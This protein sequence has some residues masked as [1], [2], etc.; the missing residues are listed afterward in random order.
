MMNSWLVSTGR[1]VFESSFTLFATLVEECGGYG[2]W[3]ICLWVS[4]AIRLLLLALCL[5]LFSSLY[6]ESIYVQR[7]SFLVLPIMA[8]TCWELM[9]TNLD[10]SVICVRVGPFILVAYDLA[11]AIALVLTQPNV[12]TFWCFFGLVLVPQLLDSLLCVFGMLVFGNHD[13]TSTPRAL[14]SLATDTRSYGTIPTANQ[15]EE[16]SQ[17]DV[18]DGHLH[19]L[20]QRQTTESERDMAASAARLGLV[21]QPSL[22][23]HMSLLRLGVL[24]DNSSSADSHLLHRKASARQRATLPAPPLRFPHNLLQ[25]LRRRR[26][27]LVSQI[28]RRHAKTYMIVQVQV[29]TYLF[30]SLVH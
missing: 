29:R 25:A 15:L 13:V 6:S 22:S 8:F 20:W 4:T 14:L 30:R 18:I 7:Y 21:C 23:L 28:S 24:R 5:L 27:S 1:D 10:T 26:V 9:R 16:A 3:W 12:A 17:D 19:R 11:I 2:I